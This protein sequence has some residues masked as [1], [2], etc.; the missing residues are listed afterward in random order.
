MV[1]RVPAPIRN[2]QDLR[3]KVAADMLQLVLVL[4]SPHD[5]RPMKHAKNPESSDCNLSASVPKLL[6]ISV[7][8][9]PARLETHSDIMAAELSDI[10]TVAPS[11]PSSRGKRHAKSGIAAAAVAARADRLQCGGCEASE[12]L[13]RG[14]V[15]RPLQPIKPYKT[16]G[17]SP[18][19][20]E[21]RHFF[22]NPRF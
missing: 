12:R 1:A 9:K 18:N 10:R 21:K 4:M 6:E 5:F 19:K 13:P 8:S 7:M 2:A 20:G 14:H 16:R 3:C 11:I 15:D 22:E 17:T